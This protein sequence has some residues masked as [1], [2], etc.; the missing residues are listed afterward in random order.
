MLAYHSTCMACLS[1]VSPV[2]DY[3]CCCSGVQGDGHGRSGPL[4]LFSAPQTTLVLV[5][6]EL[7]Q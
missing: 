3:L 1:L 2:L 5:L 4:L 6:L 7:E